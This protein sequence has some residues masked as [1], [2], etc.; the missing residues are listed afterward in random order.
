MSQGKKAETL[1]LLENF[2]KVFGAQQESQGGKERSTTQDL[3]DL[4]PT[5]PLLTL[6]GVEKWTKNEIILEI[7]D[8]P[9]P[10]IT[11]QYGK[12]TIE[13]LQGLRKITHANG[14]TVILNQPG[15]IKIMTV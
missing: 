8:A 13:F 10:P 15:K 4:I 7:D 1:H 9:L 12:T 3:D 2:Y 11:V 14:E 5:K 6:Y